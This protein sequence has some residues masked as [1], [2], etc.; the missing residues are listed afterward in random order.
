[1]ATDAEIA[2]KLQLEEFEQGDETDPDAHLAWQLQQ[3]EVSDDVDSGSLHL[4][5]LSPDPFSQ[6]PDYERP[7]VQDLSPDVD[8]D[9]IGYMEQATGLH[10]HHEDLFSLQDDERIA[11]Q[12]E[13]QLKFT[14]ESEDA[15]LAQKLF[16]EE[17]HQQ[18]QSRASR[19]PTLPRREPPQRNRPPRQFL[20]PPNSGSRRL[21]DPTL[22]PPE[23]DIPVSIRG[24]RHFHHLPRHDLQRPNFG[25][26]MRNDLFPRHM[27]PQEDVDLNDYEA[28]WE[29]AE[30]I[31]NVKGNGVTQDVIDDLPA[32]A[33]KKD[34]HGAMSQKT[35]HECR[36][37]LSTFSEG[38]AVKTLPCLHMYHQ[39]CI[40]NW[41]K[42]KGDCPICRENV[43]RES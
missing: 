19:P 35:D 1:M 30:Q 33:F 38:E 21:F 39:N 25:F 15:A 28:L 27:L 34:T 37:C 17:E 31:G 24:P 43:K 13:E 41:L 2:R 23:S 32:H 26:M 14:Q 42:R 3:S 8:A 10:G 40:D 36:I 5:Q 18:S 29:L 20:F 7:I 16:E 12:L 9:E 6:S 11:L 22:S 4:D